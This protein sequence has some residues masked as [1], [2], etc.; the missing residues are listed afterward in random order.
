MLSFRIK[1]IIYYYV[2]NFNKLVI[3]SVNED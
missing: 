3:L 1:S 2:S